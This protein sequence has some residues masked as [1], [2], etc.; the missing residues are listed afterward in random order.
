MME[1]LIR[2]A[3]IEEGKLLAEIE[4]KCFPVLEAASEDAILER[5]HTFPEN[6]FVAELDGKVIGFVNGGVTNEAHLP[7][8][9]YHNISLHCPNGKYQTV[10]GLNVLEEYRRNGIGGKLIRHLVEVSRERG[11][12]GVIL[13]CKDFRIPFYESLGFVNYGLSDSAHGNAAW[14]DMRQYFDM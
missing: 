1:V 9:M 11:K 3:R 14:Y 8:E 5:L 4:R 12:A 13:T 2:N 6:F 10:F 7:D